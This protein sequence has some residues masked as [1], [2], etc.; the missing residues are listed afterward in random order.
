M[1]QQHVCLMSKS[2]GFETKFVK[3][4]LLFSLSLSLFLSLCVRV[5]VRVLII[6]FQKKGHFHFPLK[7]WGIWQKM[8]M[9]KKIPKTKNQ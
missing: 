7:N 8:D 9:I 1:A 5:C 4:K 6:F 3:I 2:F